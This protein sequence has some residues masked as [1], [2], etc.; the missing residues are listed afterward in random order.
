VLLF[1]VRH[2][3]PIY[4]PDQLT[5]LGR[6]Q[7]EAIGRRLARF[8]VDRIYSST[9][10]RAQQTAQP[11][12]EM[13]RKEPTLLEWCHESRAY[14]DTWVEE[15]ENPRRPWAIE[16][17][18]IRRAFVSEEMRRLG[19]RWYEHPILAP[20][21]ERMK[22]GKERVDRAT[23]ELLAELG[24]IHDRE[25]GIYQVQNPPCERV[26]LFA[27]AGFGRV[28]VSSVL[29]IPYPE[30][31]TKV[32]MCHTGLTVIEFRDEGGWCIPRMLTYSSDGHLYADGL[33]TQYNYRERF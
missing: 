33:P 12:C 4:N 29:G 16:S 31:A 22:Q 14:E 1:Y 6:R 2:G 9:S 21:A 17:V 24:Y 23:D 11:L 25:A 27:H 7:A 28:F 5:P 32:D 10:I 19:N 3:D 15:P 18:P 8:G 26:A 30:F 13:L 20:Y